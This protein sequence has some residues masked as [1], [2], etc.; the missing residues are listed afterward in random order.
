MNNIRRI[1]GVFV[2][3]A[4]VLGLVLSLAGLVSVWLIKPKLG[5]VA[6]TTID[7]LTVNAIA[8]QSILQITGQAMGATIDSMDSLS[9][10][11][12]TTASAVAD[13]LPII[14]ELD[15]IM[16]RTLPSALETA[17]ES[18]YTAQEAAQVM[19]STIHSLD[20]F[21]FFLSATPLVGNLLGQTGGSYNPEKPLAESLGELAANLEDL[22]DT[23]ADISDNLNVADDNLESLGANLT[24]M[25]TSIA[26]ISSSLGEY[27]EIIIQSKSSMDGLTSTLTNIQNNLTA[28]LNGA[29]VVLTLFFV[30]FLAA[31]VIILNQGWQLYKTTPDRMPNVEH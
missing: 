14:E 7:T 5:E 30:W 11:L 3:S 17:S 28:F 6:N 25:S 10:I 1:L 9:A 19:E 2:I 12:S 26:L 16:A 22:P 15:L 13:T 20:A 4:G 24:T 29:A 27:E 31:Q 23:F 18:L 21:R 8:S